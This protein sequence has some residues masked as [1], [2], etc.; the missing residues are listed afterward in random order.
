MTILTNKQLSEIRQ[1]IERHH[2]VFLVNCLGG[3]DLVAKEMF[4]KLVKEG[5]VEEDQKNMVEEAFLLGVVIE[6]MERAGKPAKGLSYEQLKSQI[7]ARADA[8]TDNEKEAIEFA[9]RATYSHLKGLGNTVEENTNKVIIE[10]DSGLRQKLEETTKR[11]LVEG[12]ESRKTIKQIGSD[13]GEASKDYARDWVRI[14]ATETNNAFQEGML[15]NI[16]QRA[17]ED[18]RPLHEVFVFKRPASG[19]CAECKA[20]YLEKDG[21]TP[22]VFKLTELMGNGSNVGRKHNDRRPVVQSFHPYCAC[23]LS[24]LEPG[25]G[26]GADGLV[27]YVGIHE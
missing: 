24:E 10:G 14:S 27:E 12:L 1:I 17:E 15:Q 16:I 2:A 22:R 23:R 26:F 9:K 7:E 8:L 20:A 21:K 18:K 13:L 5:L 4:Q 6:E 19:A 25:F 11:K 3:K